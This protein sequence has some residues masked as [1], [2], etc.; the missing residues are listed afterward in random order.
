MERISQAGLS[1]ALTPTGAQLQRRLSSA[2]GLALTVL[3]EGLA[4]RYPSQDTAE[5]MDE[6]M[7]D[8]E[9]L[10]LKYSLPKVEAALEALRIKP[11][12]LFFPTPN[13]LSEE[14]EAQREAMKYTIQARESAER[15]RKWSEHVAACIRE[16]QEGPDANS[17]A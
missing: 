1:S 11:G 4:R 13:E 9:R 8:Y 15:Q 5:T 7:G 16:R 17:A 6:Y 10:A 14:I 2:D 12:C 3:M